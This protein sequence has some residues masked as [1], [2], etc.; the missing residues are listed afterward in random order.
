MYSWFIFVQWLSFLCEYAD[1]RDVICYEDFI[2]L[3]E[4]ENP[5]LRME[6]MKITDIAEEQSRESVRWFMNI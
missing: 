4:T 5:S 1:E 2:E 3:D 6:D